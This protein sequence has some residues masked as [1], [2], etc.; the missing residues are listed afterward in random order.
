M[1]IDAIN[2]ARETTQSKNADPLE[3]DTDIKQKQQVDFSHEHANGR[4][5]E[6]AVQN[7]NK[8]HETSA[9]PDTVRYSDSKVD[10]ESK[11]RNDKPLVLN[12]KDPRQIEALGNV[13]E[14]N[15]KL[16]GEETLI[17]TFKVRRIKVAKLSKLSRDLIALNGDK[18]DEKSKQKNQIN[19][20]VPQSDE[21]NL[22]TEKPAISFNNRRTEIE[23]IGETTYRDI[24]KIEDE[25]D[26][27]LDLTLVQDLN[28]IAFGKEV[29]IRILGGLD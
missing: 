27:R 28:E 3:T 10:G 6:Q 17:E 7:A 29:A 5:F 11:A 19:K 23:K 18:L 20:N 8:T 2:F 16:T 1:E 24:L 13:E 22:S 25:L 9:P 14:K 21:I 12:E 15:D 4:M 26:N